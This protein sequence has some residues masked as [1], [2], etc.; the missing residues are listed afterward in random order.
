[1]LC[2]NLQI[3]NEKEKITILNPT[4]KNQN[5][6]YEEI[7]ADLDNG[8]KYSGKVI[9]GCP[10]GKGVEYRKDGCNYQGH[11]LNGKWQG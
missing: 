4:M 10:N 3:G 5:T 9:N 11:F 8:S 6:Q 7:N 1:M 2:P